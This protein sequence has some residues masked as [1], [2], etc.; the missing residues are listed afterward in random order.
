MEGP[1]D[2]DAKKIAERLRQQASEDKIRVTLHGHQEMIE[3]NISYEAL[4]EALLTP[5]VI[6]NYPDH[7]RGPCCLVCGRARSGRCVHVVCTTGLEVIV[8]ITVYE[9][10]PPRWVTPFQRGD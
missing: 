9:P 7:Q 1:V 3:E 8:V 4:R 5:E 2:R 10:R 6:E